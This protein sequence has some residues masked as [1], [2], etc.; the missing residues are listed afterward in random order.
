M[1]GK[2]ADEARKELQAAGLSGE[3]LEK[4][5]PHK[6][7]WGL[8]RCCSSEGFAG[9]GRAAGTGW[10]WWDL[11]RA[12]GTGCEHHFASGALWGVP[13][14]MGYLSTALG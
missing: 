3:A 4:L 6:V 9:G 12:L 2:T 5:L 1:K 11:G 10:H 7:P 13:E 8:R 14:K